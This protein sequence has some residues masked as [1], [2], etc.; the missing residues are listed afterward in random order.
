MRSSIHDD[1][2]GPIIEHWTAPKKSFDLRDS[3]V[4]PGAGERLADAGERLADVFPVGLSWVEAA[5][6]WLPWKKG[7][8]QV[9]GWTVGVFPDRIT[10]DAAALWFRPMRRVHLARMVDVLKVQKVYL[11]ASAGPGS[12]LWSNDSEPWKACSIVKFGCPAV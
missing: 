1:L 2:V 12:A 4:L 10:L 7:V 9:A 8:G 6:D 11:P 3:G 5:S